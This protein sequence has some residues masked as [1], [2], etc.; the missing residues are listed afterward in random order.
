MQSV[1]DQSP[2]TVQ[3]GVSQNNT[4]DTNI[5]TDQCVKSVDNL[6]HK[7]L[8]YVCLNVGMYVYVSV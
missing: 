8:E 5:T 2:I 4:H 3:L 7:L 1:L 6:I